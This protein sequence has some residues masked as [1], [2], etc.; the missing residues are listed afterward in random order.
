MAKLDQIDWRIIW[1][2]IKMICIP[3]IIATIG[4]FCGF[5]LR[6]TIVKTAEG[7]YYEQLRKELYAESR[8]ADRIGHH[9]QDGKNA[10]QV[11]RFSEKKNSRLSGKLL[12]PRNGIKKAQKKTSAKSE[13]KLSSIPTKKI[14]M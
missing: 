9:Q 1:L 6:C 2:T 4:F 14:T 12:Q 5:F 10:Q 13:K 7:I 11:R 3:I 8:K